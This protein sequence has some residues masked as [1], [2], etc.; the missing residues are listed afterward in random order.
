FIP[1]S[2]MYG[3][4]AGVAFLIAASQLFDATGLSALK[5]TGHFWGDI[6][7]YLAHASETH[8]PS[9]AVFAVFLSGILLWK[10]YIKALPAVIP[11]SV[12][13]IVFG[14]IEARLLSLDLTSLGDKFGSFSGAL[15]ASVPW[16]AIPA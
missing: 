8:L 1:S 9:V 15:M 7:L 12:F 3:F 5:R 2:V 13:G 4:A 14:V 16:D 10:R 11:A 6:E